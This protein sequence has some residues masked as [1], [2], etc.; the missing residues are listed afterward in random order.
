MESEI[1][2]A[3]LYNEKLKF[4]EIEKLAKLRSNKLAYH[5]KKLEEKGV[6]QKEKDFYKLSEAAEK[7]IPYL[8][9]K[10]SSLSVVLI[11]LTKDKKVFLHSRKKRPFKNKLSLPGGRLLSGEE[12]S[13]AVKRMMK[14]KFSINAKLEKINSI[15]LEHVKN[16]DKKIHSFI[17]IL[18][19]A[20]TK[21]KIKYTEINKNKSKIIP[22]DYKLI[23]SDL[24]KEIEIMT[25]L[26]SD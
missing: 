18:V 15:T 21:E 19:T 2:K 4:N 5:I 6:L 14:E 7:L 22:S 13:D 24:D 10:R 26:T 25:F 23:K 12:I 1:L 16:K 11:A 8:S 20:S 3:F 9:D 17:L